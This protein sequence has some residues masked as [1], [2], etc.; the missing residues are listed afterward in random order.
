M[1]DGGHAILETGQ[2]LDVIAACGREIT[3]GPSTQLGYAVAFFEHAFLRE[4]RHF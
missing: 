1:F 3:L 4:R 2:A